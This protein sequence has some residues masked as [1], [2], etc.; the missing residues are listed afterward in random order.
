MGGTSAACAGASCAPDDRRNGVVHR[1]ISREAD[2]ASLGSRVGSRGVGIFSPLWQ[3]FPLILVL[4]WLSGI[5][6]VGAEEIADT[7]KD[8]PSHAK[9]ATRDEDSDDTADV[10]T[11][12]TV[13]TAEEKRG[14]KVAGDLR[15]IIDYFD[16]DGRDGSSSSDGGVGARL[17]LGADW[18]IFRNLRLGVRAAGRCFTQDCDPEWV[19]ESATPGPNGLSGGQAT[20]DQA[21][22]HWFRLQRF[23]LAVG[24]LQT[25]FVLRGGVYAK[26]L[27]RNDSNNVNITWTDGLHATFKNRGGWMSSFVLQRNA[28]NGTGSIRHSPLNFD[29]GRAR[30]TY[31]VGFEKMSSERPVAQ[32]A[33]DASYLP[34][35]LLENGN[36]EGRRADYWGL[37]GRLALRWPQRSDGIRL[38]VG[39]EVGYAPEAPT[40]EAVGL[41][42][43][44]NQLAWNVVAS[45]MDFKPDHSIGLN[46]SRTGAAWLL[47]PQY[48]P[49]ESLFE[50]RYQWWPRRWPLLEA[51]VRWREDLE[52]LTDRA[53]KRRMFDFYLRVTWE[54]DVK[55]R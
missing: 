42:G 12:S 40:A 37:V 23:N 39:T 32:L 49:N 15:P 30:N 9:P 5:S 45:L 38:R 7:S 11:E 3:W 22:L 18:G 6:W 27:D 13:D 16:V 36:P 46:Y 31:F 54:F 14:F 44:V 10:D 25:R 51:R 29:D 17:R 41:D 2:Q 24:R 19:L 8:V 35:S 26:S 20:L 53:R 50:I 33:F 55:R 1:D 4:L 21:Y 28:A 47:S 34:G 43:D 52:Q 48:R